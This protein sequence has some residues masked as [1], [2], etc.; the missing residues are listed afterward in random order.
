[1]KVGSGQWTVGGEGKPSEFLKTSEVYTSLLAALTLLLM[2]VMSTATDERAAKP[3]AANA[4]NDAQDIVFFSTAR[5]VLIR[6]HLRINGQPYTKAWDEYMDKLFAYLDLNSDGVLSK[7]EAALVPPAAFLQQHFQ[8][9]IG[10]SSRQRNGVPFDELDTNPKDGKVTR[11]E[12]KAYYRRSNFAS[13][14]IEV[15]PGQ[16]NADILTAALFK[17]LDRNGDGKLSREEVAVA[18]ESL[19]PLDFDDDE[20]ISQDELVPNLFGLSRFFGRPFGSAPDPDKTPVMILPSLL[21][22]TG[23]GAQPPPSLSGKGAEGVGGE[24]STKLVEQLLKRYDRDKNQKLSRAE[25]GLDQPDFDRLDANKD[26]ELDAA[27]LANWGNRP[28]DLILQADLGNPTK[29]NSGF[30]DSIR[31]LTGMPAKK[32]QVQL[33]PL[34]GKPSPL[35]A[36]TRKVERGN[37]RLTLEESQIDFERLPS[38]NANQ[39]DN[40][41][42]Y[43]QQFRQADTKKKGY[44]EKK[45][46]EQNPFLGGLLFQLADRDRDGKLYMRELTAFF[47]LHAK[48]RASFVS[49]TVDD[50]GRNLFEVLDTNHDGRLS[51]RELK[52]AWERL[53]PLD[54]N[55]DGFISL[56]E[57]PRQ[58]QLGLSQ[59]LNR[60][61]G[62]RVFFA[63]TQVRPFS[64]ASGKGPLWFR[65]M[66]RNGDGD[67]SPKE[68]LGTAED[69][70]KIDTNGD[71]LIDAQEAEKADA[72]FKKQLP[73]GK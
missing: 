47:D 8:G 70:K 60:N 27:E 54:R 73:A 61:F 35:S 62:Q 19:R 28:P 32:E 66:D 30:F 22:E 14:Q 21:P 51:L 72:W 37:I 34:E 4:D 6:L 46:A 31:E 23:R 2:G 40:R 17:H 59:G 71:G 29:A 20:M 56:N 16:G 9:V 39:F 43:F 15:A 5:P 41:S 52:T 65:K 36:L 69:F 25:I 64:R 3:P 42:F 55:K 10:G 48:G 63:R 58:Y 49:L 33:V 38:E 26:G 68:F 7:E 13:M 57:I 50:P 53:S 24:A 67:V 45:D 44:L 1:M 18:I 12:L 11:E